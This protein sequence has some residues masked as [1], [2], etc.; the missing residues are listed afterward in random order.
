MGVPAVSP[1]EG[2]ALAA[3]AARVIGAK[4]A[5]RREEVARPDSSALTANG[6]SFVTLERVG[7]LRG[8][9]GALDAVRPLYLDVAGNALR[10]MTDARFPELAPD[11]WEDLDV[12]V[13]V[14]TSPEPIEAG[15]IGELASALRRGIDGLILSDGARRATFLP[16]VW[17]KLPDPERFIAALLTKGGWSAGDAG[18]LT[19]RRYQAEVFHDP[20]PRAPLTA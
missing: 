19:A 9:V 13:S 5:G 15:D 11:E 8:C 14:L 16:A 20:A 18:R 6:S 4:L 1:E 2:A 17:E 12:S 10:A 7:R 3:L